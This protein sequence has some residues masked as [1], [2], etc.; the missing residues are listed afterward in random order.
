VRDGLVDS[1]PGDQRFTQRVV[2]LGEV[3]FDG[4]SFLQLRDFLFAIDFLVVGLAEVV[5]SIREIG[6]QRQCLLELPDRLAG[7]DDNQDSAQVR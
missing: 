2:C 1:A 3:R 5:V 7:V 6:L 4:K